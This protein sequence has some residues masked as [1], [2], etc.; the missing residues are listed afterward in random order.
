MRIAIA[1]YI[2]NLILKLAA[3]S[4][5]VDPIYKHLMPS[6][7]KLFKESPE[8]VN[9]I[10]SAINGIIHGLK[11]KE[12]ID[13]YDFI[14]G[15][16]LLNDQQTAIVLSS[17]E[18]VLKDLGNKSYMAS[19]KDLVDDIKKKAVKPP[20]QYNIP[21]FIKTSLKMMDQVRP[22]DRVSANLVRN[23]RMQYRAAEP[24]IRRLQMTPIP[25][26]K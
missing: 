26:K 21:E 1:G 22:E 11:A 9:E 7:I 18:G 2:R 16:G 25:P 15:L 20:N 24:F 10:K 4:S 17:M 8:K 3:Y 12:N 6:L 23:A 13:D 5:D 14:T 19:F